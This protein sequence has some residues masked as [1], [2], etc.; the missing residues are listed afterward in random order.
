MRTKLFFGLLLVAAA[1]VALARLDQPT[2][3][4]QN[5]GE[6]AP[7]LK[8]GVVDIGVLFRDYQRKDDLESTINEER[9]RMKGEIEGDQ[10]ALLRKRRQLEEGAF[11]RGSEPWLRLREEIQL[12]EYALELKAKRLEASLKQQVEEFTLRILGELE[13]TI[14]HYAE[15]NNYTLV[16]K[17]D[18]AAMQDAEEGSLAAQFQERIFR[19]QI[20]DVLYFRENIDCT[21]GVKRILNSDAWRREM[22][23]RAQQE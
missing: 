4:A 8:V 14:E 12:E 5:G 7:R 9:E 16:L 15:N 3:L 6:G 10:E 11:Q 21:E 13:A 20:S 17:I 23:R 19:A 2:T 22:E 1:L 18:R